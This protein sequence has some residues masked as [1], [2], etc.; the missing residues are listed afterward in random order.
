VDLKL[1]SEL[2][3]LFERHFAEL[4]AQEVAEGIEE[5]LSGSIT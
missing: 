1:K 2:D 3:E 5:E 4:R